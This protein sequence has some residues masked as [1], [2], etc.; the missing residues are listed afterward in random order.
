MKQA[1]VAHPADTVGTALHE[2]ATNDRIRAVSKDAG[3]RELV[4][5]E[6][7][8]RFHKIALQD[9]KKGEKIL[10]YGEAIGTATRDIATG[11]H[12]H[13]QNLDSDRGRGDRP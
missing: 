12:V 3:S 10:K 5:L 1:L 2:L 7:I 8:P 11:F 9:I 4:A 6:P 13:I